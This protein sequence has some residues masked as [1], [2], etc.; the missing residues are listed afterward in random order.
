MSTSDFDAIDYLKPGPYYQD[1]Y[2]YFDY[3]RQ[4]APVWREPHHGVVMV[5]GYDECVE[6]YRDSTTYS[7]A[8]LMAGP[9][10][11]W[12]VPLE[13]DDI[14]E[15]IERYRD[16][17]PLSDQLVTF[18][19]PKHT[20]HRAL[21]GRLITTKRLKENEDF[22]WRIADRQIDGFLARGSCEF[23][24][25]YANPFTLL[26]VADLL[27]VP[28]E[29][30]PGFLLNLQTKAADASGKNRGALEHKPLEYLYGRFTHFIE[31][32]RREPQSDVL[33]SLATATFPDGTLP[34]VRDVML[35]AS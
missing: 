26:G 32:R 23:V 7:N 9:F 20:V 21:L 6:V 10:A 19:P 29:Y 31:D 11:R 24:H 8:A 33:T 16:Q 22:L 25:D 3:L 17:L 13:G 27:G 2:P 30:H 12:P 18:D 15:I 4:R 35:L 28:E 5:T 14:S 1:P 34:E